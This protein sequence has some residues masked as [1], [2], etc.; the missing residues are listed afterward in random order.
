[1]NCFQRAL[2][3][4]PNYINRTAL[5]FSISCTGKAAHVA[6]A[7][8]LHFLLLPFLPLLPLLPPHFKMQ[9]KLKGHES[10]Y[11]RPR[12]NV[13]SPLM[14]FSYSVVQRTGG[15]I[16]AIPRKPE[17]VVTGYSDITLTLS[18]FCGIWMAAVLSVTSPRS[19]VCC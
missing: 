15:C 13:G 8:C 6:V 19:S 14:L 12:R 9:K 4:G 11:Y 7:L 16:S 1:M 2:L 10:L 17:F 5:W 18:S 3:R